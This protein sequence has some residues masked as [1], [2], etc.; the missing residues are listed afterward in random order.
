ME[1]YGFR[2][3]TRKFA[4]SVIK[5]QGIQWIFPQNSHE[6]VCMY[7]CMYEWMN[8]WMQECMNV[9][10]Y[11]CMNV[12]IYKCMIVC[13]YVCIYI[14]MIKRYVG[15]YIYICSPPDRK[16]CS[17]VR[18]FCPKRVILPQCRVDFWCWKPFKIW[19]AFFAFSP[20]SLQRM[21][22]FQL[23]RSNNTRDLC[24]VVTSNAATIP[25][26]SAA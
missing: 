10:R 14:Y 22:R 9:W 15:I 20:S 26:I 17:S 16:P 5:N 18:I 2:S 21:H 23:E 12:R 24:S 6:Y 8:A 13:V 7:G 25:E 4:T 1:H 11:E 3:V 19:G